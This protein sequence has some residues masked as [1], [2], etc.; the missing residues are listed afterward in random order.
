MTNIPTAFDHQI[1]TAKFILT[2][3]RCLVWNDPGTGK[4]RSVLDAYSEYRQT[5]KLPGTMLV[6][7]PKSIMEAAWVRDCQKFTPHLRIATAYASNR[8]AAFA[9]EADIVVTN[10]DAIKWLADN[11]QWLAGYT[12][13][14]VD[15]STAYKNRSAQRSRAAAKVAERFEYRILMTGTPMPNGVMDV[16][17]QA[18]MV[19]D[20][21]RLGANFYRFRNVVCEPQ[22]VGPAANMVQWT[23][24]DG[25][26]DAVADQ[27]SDITIRYSR[28]ECLSLPANQLSTIDITLPPKLRDLYE[29][30]KDDAL[31][32][33]ASGEI[34]AVN[35]AAMRT[36]LLQIASGAV[37]DSAHE[38]HVLDHYRYELVAELC[39][40]RQHT[41]VAFMWQHQKEEMAKALGKLGLSYQII[42]GSVT[43]KNGAVDKIVEEFQAGGTRVLL[44]HPKSG[45]HGLT[46]TKGTTTIWPSPTDNGEWYTQ[47]NQR[48]HRT[49]Q[50]QRTE[51]ILIRAADTV[52]LR[53]YANLQ[54]KV[55]KQLSLLDLMNDLRQP[56]EAA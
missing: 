44:I 26:A 30:F 55:G 51:T 22:Q 9:S 32:E 12:W 20:G 43:A 3:K 13:M 41:V 52:E 42:D 19:D 54:N 11:P 35:A 27:L 18:K 49:G 8:V 28:D 16:W 4:T 24:K 47:F 2:N 38:Y 29:K 50:T 25:A 23:D 14:V 34:D 1:H 5:T 46:L 33:L 17:H 21:E 48:I 37:Y 53:A 31:L 10:H 45:S 6:L 56:Q 7:C 39:N 15:E 36:K 40:Q